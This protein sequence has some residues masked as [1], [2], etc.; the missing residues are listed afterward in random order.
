MSSTEK[1][2]YTGWIKKKKK[3]IPCLFFILINMPLHLHVVNHVDHMIFKILG[4][5]IFFFL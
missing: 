2:L 1:A 5:T 4:P 3:E